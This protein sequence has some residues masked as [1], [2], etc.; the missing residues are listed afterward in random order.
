MIKLY[1]VANHIS[2]PAHGGCDY[3][4]V[5][6]TTGSWGSGPFPPLFLTRSEAG[7]YINRFHPG[8]CIAE[9]KI[10][11]QSLPLI[12]WALTNLIKIAIKYNTKPISSK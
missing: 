8:S 7:S 5:I 4:H 3:H 11:F 6:E 10:H 1:T 2:T 12:E 9:L